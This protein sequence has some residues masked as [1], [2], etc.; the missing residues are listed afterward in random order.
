M[1]NRSAPVS[2]GV[3]S[4]L[5]IVSLLL[6]SL[7]AK[8]QPLWPHISDDVR[9]NLFAHDMLHSVTAVA[10][11]EGMVLWT[12][13]LPDTKRYVIATV[14][15]PI[16][17]EAFDYVRWTAIEG[18]PWSVKDSLHDV[19]TYQG[20]WALYFAKRG[21]WHWAMLTLVAVTGFTWAWNMEG[22]RP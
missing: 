1:N 2:I 21:Q 15:L 6:F 11:A 18:I 12:G 5:A 22:W 16:A 9:V 8:A 3:S 4:S 20:A 19:A 13:P 14:A 7:A 17:Q 10:V